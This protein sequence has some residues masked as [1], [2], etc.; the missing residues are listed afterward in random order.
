MAD[1]STISRYYKQ[2]INVIGDDMFLLEDDYVLM[3]SNDDL[4]TY[5][6]EDE[7]HRL[8]RIAHRVYNNPLYAWIIARRNRLENMD[9]LWFGRELK[10]PP[11]SKIFK[12]GYI[13]YN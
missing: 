5:V 4:V 2:P 7:V 6:Q 9:D 11:I 13:I 10:Y 3:P 1:N 8:D 12:D